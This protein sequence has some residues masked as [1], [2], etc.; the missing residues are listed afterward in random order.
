MYR[1]PQ[2]CGILFKGLIGEVTDKPNVHAS[3]S[4]EDDGIDVIDRK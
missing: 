2:Q 3:E 4:V 1:N